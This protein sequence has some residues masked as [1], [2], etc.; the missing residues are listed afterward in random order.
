[1]KLDREILG[2]LTVPFHPSDYLRVTPIAFAATPLGM[3]FG[4]TRFASPD[5]SFRLLYIAC[6]LAT[7]IAETMIRDRFQG[8]A[9][10]RFTQEEVESWGVATVSATAPLRLVDLRTT[11]LLKLGVSTEAAR[12][13]VQ[14][15]GRKLSQAI[16]DR[17]DA[18]GL[19]YMSRLTGMTCI[20]VYDRA[21]PGKLQSAPVVEVVTL[22]DFVPALRHL[23]VSVI[24][25]DS[26]D[27]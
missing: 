2:E 12:G 5:D 13:K 16:Y 26:G 7:A 22:A 10:R 24:R 27:A 20:A 19:L 1:M 9:K 25:R 8:R 14:T 6:N 15:Q 21:V 3:G 18:D 17:T 23:N 11:G 4:K